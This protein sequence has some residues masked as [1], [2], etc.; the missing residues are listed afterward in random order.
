MTIFRGAHKQNV[1]VVC[2][3]SRLPEVMGSPSALGQITLNLMQNGVDAMAE[4]P[5]KKRK[6]EITAKQDATTVTIAVRDYGT[7]I[8]IEVQ[9]RMY[10]AFFTTKEPGKGTGLGLAICKDIA[11]GMGGKLTFTTGP[12]GTCF[13]VS[14]P[15]DQSD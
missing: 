7:G 10:D 9:K 13:E 1:D 8:P 3:L 4:L 2:S 5:R 14:V 11:E 12:D 6:L 15:V